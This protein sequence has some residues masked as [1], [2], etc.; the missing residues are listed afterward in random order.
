[1]SLQKVSFYKITS[2]ICF[3]NFYY[4]DVISWAR[5]ICLYKKATWKCDLFVVIFDQYSSWI[6]RYYAAD[7]M[8]DAKQ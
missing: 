4:F 5:K 1:M 2:V 6:L 8:R 3:S 7:L